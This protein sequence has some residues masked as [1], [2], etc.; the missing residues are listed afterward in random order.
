MKIKVYITPEKLFA[1]FLLLCG[2]FLLMLGLGNM[3]ELF[4]K[5][6]LNDIVSQQLRSGM[7][8]TGEITDVVRTRSRAQ[9]EDGTLY[10][11][12]GQDPVTGETAYVIPTGNR[13]AEYIRLL[14][15]V[16]MRKELQ[17]GDS[18]VSHFVAKI[19][20]TDALQVPDEALEEA[21]IR[22]SY[23][24]EYAVCAVSEQEERNMLWR[25]ICLI[26]CGVLLL[27]VLFAE[28][29][30]IVRVNTHS[31]MEGEGKWTN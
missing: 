27:T 20:K 29:G 23:I 14:V 31:A 4:R 25:G 22:D 28:Q 1:F 10:P 6:E 15:T 11:V 5:R 24:E 8:V 2:V 19:K 18:D 26:V 3:S 21:G 7:Y 17:E 9:Y 13:E 12:C 16:Q 30:T